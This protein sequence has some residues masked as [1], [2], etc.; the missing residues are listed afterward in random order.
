MADDLH[1]DNLCDT[2]RVQKIDRQVSRIVQTHLLNA[3]ASEQGVPRLV[4]PRGIDR[5][6]G[7]FLGSPFT[8][9]GVGPQKAMRVRLCARG[10]DAPFDES[11]EVTYEWD[12]A[13]ARR[14]LW[15]RKPEAAGQVTA[16]IV[17]GGDNLAHRAVRSARPPAR[18]GAAV[19]PG[20]AL[21]LPRQV[22]HVGDTIE[23]EPQ[24]LALPRAREDS[25]RQRDSK[26]SPLHALSTVRPSAGDSAR[27]VV[28]FL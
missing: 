13:M 3:S 7:E 17:C 18:P 14:R 28:L 20:E 4:V 9:S 25:R 22:K 26:R 2:C 27:S 16:L 6:A 12:P 23:L 5:L 19:R 1:C 11:A 8:N 15:S 10:F 21:Q 24:E